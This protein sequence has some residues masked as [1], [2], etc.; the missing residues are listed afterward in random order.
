M[1]NVEKFKKI[2]K[3]MKLVK[4]VRNG[5]ENCVVAIEL[6]DGRILDARVKDYDLASIVDDINKLDV[7]IDFENRHSSDSNVDYDCIVVKV[8]SIEL[9]CVAFLSRTQVA[10]MNLVALK[11]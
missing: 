11:K 5:F 9:E 8:P 6:I 1:S 3:S 7:K 2:T 4:R 10:I